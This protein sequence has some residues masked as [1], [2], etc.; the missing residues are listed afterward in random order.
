VITLAQLREAR[1]DPLD[2][3]ARAWTALATALDNGGGRASSGIAGPLHASGWSGADAEVSLAQLDRQDTELRIAAEE[4]CGVAP[5]VR[6]A[7]D[8]LRST[9]ARL[10]A[11]LGEAASYGLTVSEDGRVR[12]PLGPAPATRADELTAAIADVLNRATEADELLADGLRRLAADAVGSGGD[13]WADVVAD[14]AMVARLTGLTASAIPRGTPEQVRAWWT[15]LPEAERQRYLMAFPELLGALDGL[16]VHVRDRANRIALGAVEADLR[17]QLATERAKLATVTGGTPGAGVRFISGIQDLEKRLASVRELRTCLEFAPQHG[18]TAVPYL[19]G[20]SADGDGK[21]VVALGDPDHARHTAVFVPGMGAGL[22]HIGG[23]LERMR[24]LRWSARGKTKGEVATVAW[25]GYDAP[26]DLGQ[27]L[28]PGYAEKAAPQLDDFVRGL[29]ASHDPGVRDHTTVIGHSYGS[30][31]VGEAAQREGGLGADDIVAVGSPG[32]HA[33]SA[34]QFRLPP[35]HVWIGKAHGDPVPTLG[36]IAYAL[37][38]AA[39]PADRE[40]G[41]NRFTTNGS[42]GHSAYWSTEHPDSLENQ[43]AVVAGRYEDVHLMWGTAPPD[44]PP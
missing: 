39:G 37:P 9:Q 23:E 25:I 5:L 7:V 28:D 42:K 34:A 36:G 16:P 44:P 33:H 4:A 32:I 40:F 11:L 26:D 43:G 3:A 17:T 29:H 38:G 2:A 20:F 8:E 41:A 13:R 12:A 14:G 15:G 6:T 21:A 30:L 22:D 19:L 18:R 10:A 27:A 35:E 31:V 1:F 24:D